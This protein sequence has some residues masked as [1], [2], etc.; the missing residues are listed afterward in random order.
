[1]TMKSK[2]PITDNNLKPIADAAKAAR[3]ADE[4]LS[5]CRACKACVPYDSAINLHYGGGLLHTI[6]TEC[7]NKGLITIVARTSSGIQVNMV[8]R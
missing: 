2:L 6:C 8:K 5:T 7:V 3:L 4:G 1:M